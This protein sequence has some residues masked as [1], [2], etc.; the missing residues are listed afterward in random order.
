MKPP[1]SPECPQFLDNVSRLVDGMMNKQEEN[2]FLRSIEDNGE[3]LKKLEI[4]QTYKQFLA[5]KLERKCCSSNLIKCIKDS[6][7][8]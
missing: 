7:S 8:K 6:I 5:E 3:C 1:K 2:A 4:E